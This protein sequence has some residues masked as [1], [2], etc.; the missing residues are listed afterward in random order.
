V[1][2]EMHVGISDAHR[3]VH[4]ITRKNFRGVQVTCPDPRGRRELLGFTRDV[5]AM[6]S[7]QGEDARMAETPQA[8]D[9]AF[10][11]YFSSRN[12]SVDLSSF[13]TSMGRVPL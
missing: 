9:A 10:S 5:R 12:G 2:R 4:E 11:S 7:G 1:L 3:A 13:A 8:G 6:P